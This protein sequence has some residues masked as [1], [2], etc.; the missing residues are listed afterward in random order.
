M[1]GDNHMAIS[2]KNPLSK[3][4]QAQIPGRGNI[5]CAQGRSRK[6][7]CLEHSEKRLVENKVSSMV[8]NHSNRTTFWGFYS[9]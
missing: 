2:A 6:P 4:K 9:G 5:S 8:A 1:H 7:V 3:G